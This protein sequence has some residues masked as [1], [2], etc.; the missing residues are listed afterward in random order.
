MSAEKI[1][2]EK[3]KRMK[4]KGEK[5]TMITSYDYPFA[6]LADQV[7][8]DVILVGDSVGMVVLGYENTLPVTLEDILHH[9]K[10]VTRAVKRALVVADMPFLS[11]QIGV[12]EAIINAGRLIKEGLADAVKIEGGKNVTHIVKALV[13]ANIPV[14]GHIGLTPQRIKIFGRYRVR[15]KSIDEAVKLINDAKALEEA[16][17]FSIVLE[18]IPAEVAKIITEEVS[19][20]TIGIGA[21]PYCDGQVLVIHD[22]LGLFERF[23]PKFVKRYTNLSDEIRKA[24][25][26]YIADVKGK[27]FPEK[28]HS[29]FMSED[30]YKELLKR[31]GRS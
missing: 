28:E 10:A 31:L 21:G 1:T 18:L 24:I 11:Y 8:I 4:K 9:T 12:K 23:V 20:P 5:I 16:G 15:G 25:S 13:D 26:E 29:F 7:G 14:M 30:E 6:S 27:R 17:V 3:L 2:I 19:I 22:I